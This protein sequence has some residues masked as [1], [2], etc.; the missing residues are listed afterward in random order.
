MKARYL[1]KAPWAVSLAAA[2]A[3]VLSGCGG[4][5]GGGAKAPALSGTAAIG[6]AIV[7]GTVTDRRLACCQPGFNQ[8]GKLR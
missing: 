7:G 5:S 1:V 6:A 2:A 4:G 3:L 8:W